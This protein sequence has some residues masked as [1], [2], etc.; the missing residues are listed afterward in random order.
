VPYADLA[1][2]AAGEGNTYRALKKRALFGSYLALFALSYYFAA[3]LGLGLRFQHSQIGVIWP[4]NA[5]L[6]AALV[7]TPRK[8]WWFILF[9]GALAHIAAFSPVVPVWRW[10]WQITSNSLFIT[11][12]AEALRR[13]ADFPLHFGNRRQVVAYIAIT[14][15]T[16]AL[17]VLWAPSFVRSLLGLE[18]NTSPVTALLRT[19]LT[20]ETAILLVAPIVIL[21]KRE[22]VR[23]AFVSPAR[24]RYEAGIVL[25]FLLAVGLLAFG[26]KPEFARFP[27]LLL[28]FFPPLLWAAV[29]FGPIG[30]STSL[31]VVAAL[32]I[33][34]TAR[35]LGP[36]VLPT[37]ADQVLSL[38]MFW[39]ALCVPVMLL[40]AVISEREHAED[41]LEEQRNQLA[42]VTRL[43][44]VG[45]MSAALAH[46]LTQPLATILANAQAGIHLLT[47]H[48]ENVEELRDILED[49]TNEEKQAANIISRLR[50]F[51]KHG[52][53]HA[54]TLAM[55]KVVRDALTL[56][57]SA[58]EMS[59]VEV[60]TQ[61]A[62]GA[63][64]RGDPVQLLQVL[65]NLI[66]NACESMSGMPG[67]DRQLLVR[68]AQPNADQV[69]I[70]VAD[71]GVGLPQDFE[72]GM[73]KPFFTTKEKGLGLGLAISRSIVTAHGGKLWGENNLDGGA[74]FHV[75]LPL[76]RDTTTL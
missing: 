76:V 51:L 56:C 43:T 4:P 34:G 28:W 67:P 59:R 6:L 38:Q 73:S 21:W 42:H 48:P 14:F 72:D 1:A 19:T 40:A 13:T 23:R 45:E 18:P 29:R 66:V 68:I 15:L 20:N 30:A 75:L 49:I 62:V 8:H 25:T 44:T 36:F 33:F 2:N 24:R 31:F 71:R 65:L 47:S 39:I 55:E 53:P 3:R 10:C 27:S 22:T 50:M 46:E 60:Q 69:E 58:I 37:S 52:K 74:A 35:Q 7:R 32:S 11:V 64:V 16:S 63:R 70:Q 54:E 17:F 9:A 5:L 61:I 12:T 57:R 41:A 26:T